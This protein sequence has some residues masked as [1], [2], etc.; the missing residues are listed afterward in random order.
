MSDPFADV[1]AASPAIIKFIVA[2]LETRVAD[3][4]MLPVI[5]AYLDRLDPPEG[6]LIVDIGCGTG[7]TTRRIA[8]RFGQASV[9]GIERSNALTD[10]AWALV[11]AGVFGQP[12]ADALEAEYL[13][14]AEAGI[15]YGFL[16]FVTMIATKPAG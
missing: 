12:L 8:D 7:G 15:L 6:G 4:N 16:P 5:D 1:D 9:L 14:Q 10:K 2:G 13:R 3:S 11:G